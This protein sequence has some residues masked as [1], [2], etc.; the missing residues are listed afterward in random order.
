MNPVES[1]LCFECQ[2]QRL[3]GVLSHAAGSVGV[4]IIVGGPQYRVGSHRQFVLLA[5]ALARAGHPT[6]RFDYRGMGDSEGDLRNFEDVGADIDAAVAALRRAAPGVQRLVL[7]GL[8]DGASAALMH[9]DTR[10]G[11]GIDGIVLVNPWVRTQASLAR[12]QVKYYYRQRLMER[13]FWA[14]LLSGKVA[15]SAIGGLVRNIRAAAERPPATDA[16]ALSYPERMARG[17]QRFEGPR[18]LLL[19]EHDYTAREFGEHTAASAGW[20]EAFARYPAQPLTLAGADHTCSSPDALSQL[21]VA[22]TDWLAGTF[23]TAD[24]S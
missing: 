12:T 20:Q 1:A 2:G 10:S 24:S 22:T 15:F 9:I 3:L 7:W 17:W 5:R 11:R 4:V 18:L 14:K 8:C 13:G 21:V 19:S 6:L 16:V 23:A